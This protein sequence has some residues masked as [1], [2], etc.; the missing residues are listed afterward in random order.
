[1]ALRRKS[2]LCRGLAVIVLALLLVPQAKSQSAQQSQSPLKDVC[3]DGW[4]RYSCGYGYVR[5]CVSPDVEGSDDLTESLQIR[6][7][8]GADESIVPE[9]WT[10]A[11][12]EQCGYMMASMSL[13]LG[14]HFYTRVLRLDSSS[15]NHRDR[16]VQAG[17]YSA[18]KDLDQ[19][20]KA[21]FQYPGED[22]GRYEFS[23]IVIRSLDKYGISFHD[24]AT[25]V[26]DVCPTGWARYSCRFVRL[27]VSPTVAGSYDLRGS[28]LMNYAE[29][30]IDKRA[31]ALDSTHASPYEVGLAA[32][33]MLD[34]PSYFSVVKLDSSDIF[35]GDLEEAIQRMVFV[36][37]PTNFLMEYARG[38]KEGNAWFDK[39]LAEMRAK[40]QAV[41]D[42]KGPQ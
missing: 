23:P 25:P 3:P 10:H 22:N 9:K 5:L 34:G 36:P 35:G 1:M 37:L 14:Y 39:T 26:K 20:I 17:G 7:G 12:L 2:I 31:V 19:S 15:I 38:A 29:C 16:N 6:G 42:S 40:E 32:A 28:K 24:P 30:K 41:K 33:A 11:T 4:L 13:G 27:C 21:L 8:C 18:S